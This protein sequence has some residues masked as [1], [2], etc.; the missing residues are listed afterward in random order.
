MCADT[1]LYVTLMVGRD[2]SA[3]PTKCVGVCISVRPFGG[4][5]GLV[6]PYKLQ[7]PPPLRPIPRVFSCNSMLWFQRPLSPRLVCAN[8]DDHEPSPRVANA[9]GD[10]LAGAFSSAGRSRSQDPARVVSIL[11]RPE[12]H[13]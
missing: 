8:P 12:R 3:S 13:D 9:P 4:T 7:G 2:E 6:P 5:R 1:Q 11:D 10:A